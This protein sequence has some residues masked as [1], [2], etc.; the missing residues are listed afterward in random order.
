MKFDWIYDKKLSNLSLS[1]QIRRNR[2]C[3]NDEKET[4][5]KKYADINLL[6]D[7]KKAANEIV[8]YL[9]S[10]KKII[11]FGHDDP[12][13]I[14]ATYI[15]LDFFRKRYF[16]N[17]SYYIPNRQVEHYGIQKG[18]I[19]RILNEKIDLL[20]TVDNGIASYD[21]VDFLNNKNVKVIITDH[22]LIPEKIPQA[23]AVVNPKREDSRYP[24]RFIA[25]VGV[26]YLL[27]I[28]I[29][30]IMQ[31]DLSDNYLFWTALGTL[32]DRVPL[33][34]ANR[35]ILKEAFKKWKNFDDPVIF[36]TD[37]KFQTY[38]S[39]AQKQKLMEALIPILHNG[40]DLN[41]EH[42]SLKMMLADIDKKKQIYQRLYSQKK[43]Y[44]LRKK[45][46]D[47][48]IKYIPEK[49]GKFIIFVDVNDKVPFDFAGYFTSELADKNY[50]PVLILK[51]KD[52]DIWACEARATLGFN[53]IDAFKFA[54]DTL[55]QFGGHAQAAGF[56]IKGEN[57]SKFTKK[58][59]QFVK[60]TALNK[61]EKKSI[62]IDAVI[63]CNSN[64]ISQFLSESLDDLY[65]FGQDF[66]YPMILAENF[67]YKNSDLDKFNLENFEKLEN[68]TSYDIVFIFR[69]E[70][71]SLIDYKIK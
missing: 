10:G 57:I 59:Q 43:E 46:V 67:S 14:T 36:L 33:K 2:N 7:L 68:E 54:Q 4:D 44:D 61:R 50:I 70:T 17:I 11:I 20:I 65:P 22:H 45:Q 35:I 13:G 5:I 37:E 66:P 25:G 58:F 63:D 19:D 55:I 51:R 56:T 71:L 18:L 9:K 69:Q 15:L 3:N 1:T 12:D 41:G 62:K 60:L 39:S 31:E 16:N 64:D 42:Q 47:N 34:N 49:L 38:Q 27:L 8:N 30:E 6:T 52:N 21:A 24:D 28:K 23:F 26:A 48:F 29:A 53:L 40:R 32:A